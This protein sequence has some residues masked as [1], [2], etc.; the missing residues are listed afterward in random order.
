MHIISE[1][2][3]KIFWNELWQ[4]SNSV[5][6]NKTK[7]MKNELKLD[8]YIICHQKLVNDLGKEVKLISIKALSESIIN[9]YSICNSEK[10]LGNDR[11]Q[12]YLIFRPLFS[13]LQCFYM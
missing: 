11:A 7:Q 9:G 13:L 3:K 1:K 6:S 4:I 10:Y 12:N 8:G 2:W 5:S